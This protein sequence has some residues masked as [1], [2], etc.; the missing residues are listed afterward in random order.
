[1]HMFDE[2]E[3]SQRLPEVPPFRL[4]L[5]RGEDAVGVG[6]D[7]KEGGVAQI[8]QTGKPDDDVEA[9]CKNRKGKGVCGGVDIPL[10]ADD[11]RKQGGRDEKHGDKDPASDCALGTLPDGGNQTVPARHQGR[12]VVRQWELGF[13][14]RDPL[15]TWWEPRVP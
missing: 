9:E 14:H 1:M 13:G 12:R 6:A 4:N 7:G 8:E 3:P 5:V 15:R 2:A 11:D 10:I